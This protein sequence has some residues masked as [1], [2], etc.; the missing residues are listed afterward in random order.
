MALSSCQR[1]GVCPGSAGIHC[2][3]AAMGV[4]IGGRVRLG[5]AACMLGLLL[6]VAWLIGNQNRSNREVEVT[7]LVVDR[8]QQTGG[9]GHSSPSN[10]NR[11]RPAGPPVAF[12]RPRQRSQGSDVTTGE[13]AQLTPTQERT[14]GETDV[15][16]LRSLLREELKE[17]AKICMGA[18]PDAPLAPQ[19]QIE[20]YFEIGS[21]RQEARIES[22][23]YGERSESDDPQLLECLSEL[24][25]GD[26]LPAEVLDVI[27]G[28]ALVVR[29]GPRVEDS[30]R[31]VSSGTS[32]Q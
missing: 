1:F 32:V 30:E 18:N 4:E 9:S 21:Y 16:D 24:L 29:L 20:L 23:S 12:H 14:L 22:V 26:T 28:G 15:D 13:P 17:G 6:A 11:Q 7:P 19:E 27:E 2:L 5:A 10:K 3:G 8:P 25:G 31:P